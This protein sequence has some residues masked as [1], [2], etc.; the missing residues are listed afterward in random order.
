MKPYLQKNRQRIKQIQIRRTWIYLIYIPYKIY[1]Y[2]L[3]LQHAFEIVGTMEEN[4][5]KNRG[6]SWVYIGSS[7][8]LPSPSP[9]FFPPM[10]IIP[11]LNS[12]LVSTSLLVSWTFQIYPIIYPYPLTPTSPLHVYCS[13]GPM[14]TRGIHCPTYIAVVR[15]RVRMI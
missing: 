15:E 6:D 10:N 3:I 13:S 7:S 5:R 1:S 2:R 8:L 4:A 9:S 14:Q 12:L 11:P